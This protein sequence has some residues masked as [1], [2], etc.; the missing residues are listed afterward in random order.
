MNL[1]DEY[2]NP[3]QFFNYFL[4]YRENEKWN[5]DYLDT[6]S[7]HGLPIKF[8]IVG[9]YDN[10]NKYEKNIQDK[11]E[12]FAQ[13]GE[14]MLL[15]YIFEKI[16]TTNKYYVEFGGWDGKHLS[17]TYYFRKYENW[18]GLLLEGNGD[19]VNSNPDR[20]KI[21]LHHEWLTEENI[22][23]IFKKYNVPNKFDL[24]SIDVDS[25]DYYIWRG[26]TNYEANVV[27]I[28]FNPA[29]PNESPLSVEKNKT[30]T[31]IGY[32]GANL[33]SFYRLGKSKDYEFVTTIRWNAIFV[34]KELLSKLNIEPISEKE[35]IEKFF[36]PNNFWISRIIQGQ[37][38][39][40][41]NLVWNKNL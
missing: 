17:N 30:D 36:K 16:D 8:G 37:F 13:N 19:K 39:R 20:E 21:N 26:L 41:R 40:N 14:D 24:L 32:F 2:V 11:N 25:E 15:K 33:L 3:D 9:E 28:E 7:S 23:D 18:S 27:I 4:K 34:K 1:L 31:N 6:K 10:I 29:L 35:C 22:N 12:N 5:K 38:L